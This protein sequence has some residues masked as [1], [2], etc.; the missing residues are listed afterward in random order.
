MWRGV[1]GRRW[2]LCYLSLQRCIV[3]ITNGDCHSCSD[4]R[5]R[6]KYFMC[7]IPSPLNALFLARSD[8]DKAQ[9]LFPPSYRPGSDDIDL[10]LALSTWT[11]AIAT[12]HWEGRVP[13]LSTC[14]TPCA[15]TQELRT[16]GTFSQGGIL[17]QSQKWRSINYCCIT[18]TV[19]AF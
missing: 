14:F 10:S 5:R 2:G 12:A 18:A 9:D 7:H 1:E 15:S 19:F 11:V 6:G 13:P 3:K 17:F 16:S 4:L 8:F